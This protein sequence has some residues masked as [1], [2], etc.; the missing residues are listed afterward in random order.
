MRLLGKTASMLT[1]ASA[2]LTLTA[3]V[4][5]FVIEESEENLKPIL[6]KIEQR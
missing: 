2:I 6:A 4:M 5:S 3:L 1:V